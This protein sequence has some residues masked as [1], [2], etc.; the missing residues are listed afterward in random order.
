V[1]ECIQEILDR[2]DQEGRHMF[3]VKIVRSRLNA[4]A[5]DIAAAYAALRI[6]LA[7]ERLD[8]FDFGANQLVLSSRVRDAIAHLIHALAELEADSTV[9]EDYNQGLAELETDGESE[10]E[11]DDE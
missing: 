2:A 11:V 8:N 10:E 1:N 6:R 7:S 3:D 5:T 9:D 4:A